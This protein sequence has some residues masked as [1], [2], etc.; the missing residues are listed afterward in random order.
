MNM[1]RRDFLKTL[2]A[3][4]AAAAAGGGVASAA[5]T[6]PRVDYPSGEMKLNLPGYLD[7]V[8]ERG[9]DFR[10]ALQLTGR[11]LTGYTAALLRT[12]GSGPAAY[13]RIAEDSAGRLELCFD[14]Q[15]TRRLRPGR[16]PWRLV[17][18]SEFTN[19]ATVVLAGNAT[20]LQ[21]DLWK[22]E[23][24]V[25]A[26]VPQMHPLGIIEKRNHY[27]VGFRAKLAN[28]ERSR[29]DDQ[30]GTLLDHCRPVGAEIWNQGMGCRINFAPKG[31]S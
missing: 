20:I 24:E 13:A 27:E 26:I 1:L 4:A 29:Y 18:A 7:L 23:E 21:D 6:S 25:L 2:S 15:S 3:F 14:G 11:V 17:W 19:A 16:R 8:V 28:G 30:V 31:I 9:A 12:D 5:S 10:M 22:A